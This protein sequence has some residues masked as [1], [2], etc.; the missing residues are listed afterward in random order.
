M[1]EFLKYL[2]N[3]K[4]LINLLVLAILVLALPIGITLIQRQNILK[5][6]ASVEPIVLTGPNIKVINGKQFLT[7]AEVTLQLTSKLG[8]PVNASPLVSP[9]PTTTPTPLPTTTSS[10]SPIP[11][12]SPSPSVN[13]SNSPSPSGSTSTL[14]QSQHFFTNIGSFISDRIPFEFGESN[15]LINQ[16]LAQE[17]TRNGNLEICDERIIKSCLTAGGETGRMF[18]QKG[19]KFENSCVIHS[20]VTVCENYCYPVL[21]SIGGQP[22]GPGGG[23]SP[24]PT[25][26][27]SSVDN[28]QHATCNG[29]RTYAQMREELRA[30]FYNGSWDNDSVKNAYLRTACPNG[31]RAP[32]DDDDV[33]TCKGNNGPKKFRD[34]KNELL[35]IGYNGSLSVLADTIQ[36]FNNAACP[37]GDP[38]RS[39]RT[40]CN[41][42]KTIAQLVIDLK[43]ASY[44]GPWRYSDDDLQR[45]IEAYNSANRQFC[46]RPSPPPPSPSPS[47]SVL[48]TLVPT[49]SPGLCQ[50]PVDFSNVERKLIAQGRLLDDQILGEVCRQ[51]NQQPNCKIEAVS[52]INGFEQESDNFFIVSTAGRYW[53]IGK[54]NS[55]ADGQGF[56]RS[57]RALLGS[58]TND[59]LPEFNE[60]C[61]YKSSS[62]VCTIDNVSHFKE[63]DTI[64]KGNLLY[65]SLFISGHGRF[66]VVSDNQLEQRLKDNEGSLNEIKNLKRL[67][68]GR[69]VLIAGS[70]PEAFGPMC[71]VNPDKSTPCKIDIVQQFSGFD[72][73]DQNVMLVAAYGKYWVQSKVDN[74]G[75]RRVISTGN[76]SDVPE[77]AKIC[78]CGTGVCQIDEAS[79]FS[80]LDASAQND[81]LVTAYGR[82]FLFQ[83]LLQ[84][85]SP[86]PSSSASPSPSPSSSASP[87]PSI[88]PVVSTV[89]FKVSETRD[90]LKNALAIPYDEEPKLINYQFLDQQVG[91]KFIWVE[92]IGSDDSKDVQSVSVE[93]LDKPPQ[94]SS[95][96]CTADVANLNTVRFTL[97]GTKFGSSPGR[98]M[99]GNAAVPLDGNNSWSNSQVKAVLGASSARTATDAA[100]LRSGIGTNDDNNTEYTITLVR[101]DGQQDTQK[102]AVGLTS[103]SLGAQIFCRDQSNFAAS[104][105]SMVLVGIDDDGKKGSKVK[106]TVTIDPDGYIR[107]LNNQIQIG[108]TYRLSLKAAKSLRRIV[109]FTADGDTTVVPNFILPVGDIFPNPLGDGVINSGDKAVLNTQWAVSSPA[110]SLVSGDFNQDSRVNSVDWACM[111]YDFG[112]SDQP[113]L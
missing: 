13:P 113:E 50:G 95:V 41:G 70:L 87:S 4:N 79:H 102:C 91:K 55:A 17:R 18:C 76:W 37:L 110:A 45:G 69:F 71:D 57:V 86:S 111:R 105:V 35:K 83:G 104:N 27:G 16:A 29:L 93:L 59:S 103:L 84:R 36:A 63:F 24:A 32:G 38:N 48:A 30:A 88:Q 9:Q 56:A 108:K 14:I 44:P 7:E 65:N 78:S 15:F 74:S 58:G 1:N 98:V 3:K 19:V 68:N 39:V 40:Q 46:Q 49:A 22:V 23:S 100:S 61:Q 85:S 77:F 107:N 2:K 47:P 89:S 112:S 43:A 62:A 75:N 106:Q 82:Y 33:L 81:E 11:S 90:G 67:S 8:R 66:V 60:I 26:V 99:I 64:N 28:T 6:R 53:K 31:V 51:T 109:T 21:T 34:L 42:D 10:S 80:G 97:K 52:H 72:A 94:I 96:S 92:F 12:L 54:F 5:S 101:Q 20:S 25:P 73:A